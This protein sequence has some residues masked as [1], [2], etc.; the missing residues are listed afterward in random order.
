M[1]A[2][3]DETLKMTSLKVNGH[4]YRPQMKLQE[5]NIFTG[6][7]DS[8]HRVGVWSRGGGAWSWGRVH[9]R[10]GAWSWGGSGPSG[11][12]GGVP[13]GDPPRWLLLRAVCILLECI[14]VQDC[15]FYEHYCRMM[16]VT[17]ETNVTVTLPCSHFAIDWRCL[18][19]SICSLVVWTHTRTWHHR[20]IGLTWDLN[21]CY[22]FQWRKKLQGFK[23]N[24]PLHS[25]RYV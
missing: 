8:V 10:G 20:L 13:G 1:G 11:V 23:E 25:K 16:N 5:G 2:H 12:P 18:R 15:L 6:V 4:N 22:Q 9:G 3:S 21:L 24:N 19:I 17:D 7:C 14:L